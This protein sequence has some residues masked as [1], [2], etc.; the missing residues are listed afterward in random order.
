MA[1]ALACYAASSGGG[2]SASRPRDRQPFEAD[3][4][5]SQVVAAEHGLLRVARGAQRL[6]H[7]AADRA[8]LDR[9]ALALVVQVADAHLTAE[10]AARLVRREPRERAH[11]EDR[12]VARH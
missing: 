7:A 1:L 2:S 9:R 12:A 3:R 8:A 4:F 10:V 6:E 11:V 5:G